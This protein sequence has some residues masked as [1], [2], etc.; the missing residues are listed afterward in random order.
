MKNVVPIIEMP[1]GD[2]MFVGVEKNNNSMK[3]KTNDCKL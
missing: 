1:N 3:Q 2:Y